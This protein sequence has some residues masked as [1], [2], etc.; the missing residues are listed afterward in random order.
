MIMHRLLHA[1]AAAAFLAAASACFAPPPGRAQ[2][3]ASTDLPRERAAEARADR[4]ADS[5]APSVRNGR[6]LF[7]SRSGD[8]RWWFDA[9]LQVDGALYIE[10]LNSL[11]DGALL[12]RLTFAMK[13]GLYRDWETE[14]GVDF[15][16][17]SDGKPQITLRDML[18]R[19]APPSAWFSLQAGNFKEPFG[20]EQLTSDRALTFMERSSASE[21]FGLGRRLGVQLRIR[22]SASAQATVAVMGHK[23]GSRIDKGQRDEG[24]AAN[25]RATV[26]PLNR[27]GCALHLGLAGSWKQPDAVTDLPPNTIEINSR[28]ETAVF[29]PKFLHTGDIGGV[30]HY[31]RWGAEALLIAGPLHVQA[32]AMETVIPRWGGI[33]TVHLRGAY[34]QAALLLTGESR[35]YEADCGEVGTVDA[36]AHAWGALELAARLTVTDLND[37]DALV[38]GGRAGQA[39][40]GLNYYP[41]PAILL[42]L[43][44]SAVDL[45]QH[46]TRKGS[47]EGD[48]DHAFIQMRVQA[49][50]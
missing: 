25:L 30:D 14:L 20:L 4:A 1:R 26:A 2:D 5:L 42:Q 8:F 32:E 22:P 37:P 44:V 7:A 18:V 29:D 28:L 3:A 23:A 45:D 11:S 10:H 27:H 31:L 6:L 24:Y 15:G 12:R 34:A 19:Y 49:G 9:R 38:F 39:T 13:A 16:E 46:A 48:D 41:N 36:P 21:A 43:D 17:Q 47:L 40:L 35:S 33:A 50:F